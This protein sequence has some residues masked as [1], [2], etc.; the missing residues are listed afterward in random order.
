MKNKE[1]KQYQ[2]SVIIPCFGNLDALPELLKR[3]EIVV[4]E[5]KL[6][7][8]VILVC[9]TSDLVTWQIIENLVSKLELKRIRL[10]RNFGQHPAIWTG[11]SEARG[12]LISIID[13]DLQDDP[14]IIHDM[15]NL[16]N[17]NTYVIYSRTV[18]KYD[19]IF[20]RAGRRILSTIMKKVLGEKFEGNVGGPFLLRREVVDSL[21][22]M[23]ER[24]VLRLQLMWLGYPYAIYDHKKNQRQSG[25]SSY[26]F[27]KLLDLS[28]E[29]I[30]FN[31]IRIFKILISIFGAFLSLLIIFLVSNLYLVYSQE[32]VPG[33]MSTVLLIGVGFTL[34][35]LMLSTIGYF[36]ILG[37]YERRSRPVAIA[38]KND[39]N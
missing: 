30:N 2:L 8:E 38:F 35:N 27:R 14:K 21:L 9:D 13:C 11:L 16:L 37:I 33:W 18:G 4:H 39:N 24:S 34:T 23:K 3:I 25:Q 6:E 31:P 32:T 36:V 20:R 17:Q 22:S 15:H 12:E 5:I 19:H 7:T 29:S 10:I 26:S 1:S 28:L